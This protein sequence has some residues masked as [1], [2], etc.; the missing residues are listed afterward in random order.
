MVFISNKANPFLRILQAGQL[1]GRS[2]QEGA[3]MVE[4]AIVCI[5]VIPF[6]IVAIQLLYV[7]FQVITL[8]FVVTDMLRQSV[9]ADFTAIDCTVTVTPTP[10]VCT[11]PGGIT[12]I[13]CLRQ[14]VVNRASALGVT[15]AAGDVFICPVLTPAAGGSLVD[16]KT[17]CIG[18]FNNQPLMTVYARRQFTFPLVNGWPFNLQPITAG[19]LAVGRTE[20]WDS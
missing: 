2:A 18:N 19:G 17:A 5:L 13:A 14:L 3:A 4:F 7:A 8:Q 10:L 11:C 9:V 16:N 12:N 6:M 15:I 20:P 1:P